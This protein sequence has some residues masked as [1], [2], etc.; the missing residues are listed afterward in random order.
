MRFNLADG[1]ISPDDVFY[2]EPE[3]LSPERLSPRYEDSGGKLLMNGD[4]FQV[5][6]PFA[7]VPWMEAML[8]CAIRVSPQGHSMRPEHLFGEDWHTKTGSMEVDQRW[9]DKLLEFTDYLS[10]NAKDDKLSFKYLVSNTLMRGPSDMVEALIGGDNLC[11]G[12][13]EHPD[14]LHRLMA[15]CSDVF[16]G[17]A[18]A[19]LDHIDRFN[20]GYCNLFGIWAP[21]TSI[22]TQDDAS[23]LVSPA[24]YAEFMLPYQERI[25]SYFE[26]STIHL[27][28]GSLHTV[29]WVL[30]SSITAV[31]VSIDPQ[32]YGPTVTE[33]MPVFA[34]M[35]KKKPIL[36]EGPMLKEEFEELLKTLSPKGLYIWANI[37]S[38]EDRIKTSRYKVSKPSTIT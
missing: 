4:V 8:G 35:Q 19:Q 38:P 2:L 5:E 23:A 13:Y 29:D 7:R 22:R 1:S 34:R 17:I 18:K 6:A 37:E 31:Q 33:L 32:P 10:S 21:G 30:D 36:I 24:H 11:A 12:I 14:E 20:S 3:M 28:S 16:I 15:A 9:I 27:H 25:A 26:Y